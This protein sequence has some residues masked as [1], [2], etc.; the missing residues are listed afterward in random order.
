MPDS[1]T[2]ESVDGAVVR[3]AAIAH[4]RDIHRNR[5]PVGRTGIR[6]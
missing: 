4:W 1:I 5:W 2:H 3:G 6:S